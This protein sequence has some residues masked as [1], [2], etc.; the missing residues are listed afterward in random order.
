MEVPDAH[1]VAQ[2]FTLSELSAATNDFSQESF[3][4]EG[5]FGRVYKG[6]LQNTGQVVAV[7]Q[8]DRGGL[9]GHREFLV[10]ILI[11]N[12]LHH[13]NLVSLIGYCAQHA[14]RL[15]V[16]EYMMLGSLDNHLHG[17]HLQVF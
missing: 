10:E 12:V 2:T 13:P 14:Q 16:Y 5:G 3:I 4:G 9:Q 8:M 1:T 7:K 17:K 6:V 11:L 15:V